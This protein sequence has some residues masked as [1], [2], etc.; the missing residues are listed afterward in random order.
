MDW[1]WLYGPSTRAEWRFSSLLRRSIGLCTFLD[2]GWVCT[3]THGR[4]LT[5]C[6][7]QS[8][9][10]KMG[11]KQR[12]IEDDERRSLYRHLV[13][14]KHSMIN[15]P[16]T[17]IPTFL[18]TYRTRAGPVNWRRY[19]MRRTLPVGATRYKDCQSGHVQLHLQSILF[20]WA[21]FR[22][23]LFWCNI[24]TNFDATFD[25][26][27]DDEGETWSWS[28]VTADQTPGK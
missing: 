14:S 10:R 21:K 9:Q 6:P 26:T 7:Y 4:T 19:E 17:P 16:P 1:Y 18:K 2:A 24:R 13:I 5:L 27:F 15:V 20:L 12:T 28:R 11:G 22:M 23:F 8:H 25:A 3:N